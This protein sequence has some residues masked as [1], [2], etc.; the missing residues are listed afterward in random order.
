MILT[1]RPGCPVQIPVDVPQRR[2][3]IVLGATEAGVSA[4]FHLG[5]A[6]MLLEQDSPQIRRWRPPELP[7]S[8]SWRDDRCELYRQLMSLTSGEVRLGTRVT[9]IHSHARRVHVASGESFVYD[10]LVST[11][12]LDALRRL[13]MDVQPDHVRGVEWW[14]YWLSL[15]DIEHIDPST[16]DFNGD[17]DGACAGKR[18]ADFVRGSLWARY[19]SGSVLRWRADPLFKPR[20]VS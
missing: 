4:A 12:K 11:L 10:K 8:V 13:I 5:A 7:E 14:H 18:V 19:A 1:L 3:V 17:V 9:A 6:A 20:L 2:R 16:Q 15:R